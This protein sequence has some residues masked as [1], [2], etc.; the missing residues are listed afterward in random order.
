MFT[1]NLARTVSFYDRHVFLCYK[2]PEP[3]PSKVEGFESYPLPKLL[4]FAVKARKNDIVLKVNS[5]F[6]FFGSVG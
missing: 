2:S 4:S 5:N 1:E 3:W 6:F